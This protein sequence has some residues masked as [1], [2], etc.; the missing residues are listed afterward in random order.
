MHVEMP[1]AEVRRDH[2]KPALWPASQPALRTHA[3]ATACEQYV[4]VLTPL[5]L[6]KHVCPIAIPT[7]YTCRRPQGTPHFCRRACSLSK[8]QERWFGEY[9]I[10]F[11]VRFYKSSVS[12]TY[13][14]RVLRF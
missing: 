13:F 12:L 6:L 2:L 14:S 1:L 5:Y 3:N 7:A 8:S 10:L 9:R 4:H 11:F